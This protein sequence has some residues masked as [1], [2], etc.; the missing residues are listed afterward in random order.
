V[1][2]IVRRDMGALCGVPGRQGKR[3]G[4]MCA[5]G[6]HPCRCRAAVD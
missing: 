1:I 6:A 3:R 4:I 5:G 2:S